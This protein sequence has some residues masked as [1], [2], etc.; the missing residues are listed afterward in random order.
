MRLVSM[1][2]RKDFANVMV[3][4]VSLVYQGGLLLCILEFTFGGSDNEYKVK[5]NQF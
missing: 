3:I 2:V 5:R 4:A 1:R